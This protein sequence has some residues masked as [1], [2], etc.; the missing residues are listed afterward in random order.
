MLG[1]AAI[2][3]DN[4]YTL[5]VNGQKAQ[6]GDNWE[7]P[8]AAIVTSRLKAGQNELLIVA[9]NAGN[10]PNPAGL[11]CELRCQ[12]EDGT[13]AVI[14]TDATWEWTSRQPNANGRY[15]RPPTDWQPAVAVEHFEVWSRKLSGPL[16]ALLARG[17]AGSDLMVRA[18]LVKSDFLMR[19][20][21]R[22]NRD[23]IVTVRPSELTTLEA[24]D[25][26]NGQ[27]LADTLARGGQKLLA[28]EWESPEAF[29]H[30]LYRFA[31]AREPAAAE[32]A[33]LKA[34]LGEK[35]TAQ[36]IEDALWTVI[37]LPEFQLVR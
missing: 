14:A 10:G 37:M 33:I 1:L 20:L 35:L 7:T 3:C 26:A 28:R 6:A 13:V 18:S 34:S 22:P 25:L 4:S 11:F 31:L 17:A 16:A 19:T 9:K 2:A 5:F 32:L 27:I 15:S 24:I 12:L 36:G 29:V 21:G 30:W 23:Q 8:D